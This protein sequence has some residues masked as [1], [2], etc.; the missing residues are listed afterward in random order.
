LLYLA[1]GSTVRRASTNGGPARRAFLRVATGLTLAAPF[2]TA[3]AG[4]LLERTRIETTDLRLRL[5]GLPSELEGLKLLQLSDIHLSP[6][7]SVETL[8]YVIGLSNELKPDIVFLTGD[9]ITTVYDPL[10]ECLRQLSKLRTRYGIFGCHGN[11]EAHAGLEALATT[12]GAQM[13]IQFLRGERRTV[14][15]GSTPL[16]ITGID[17]EPFSK[18]TEYLKGAER[19]LGSG[20]INILM[21][22]NPDVFPVAAAKG[23]DLM[24]AGHTHGGQVTTEILPRTLNPAR[25]LTPYV[26]GLYQSGQRYCYVNRGIGTIG[27]PVRIGCTPEVTMIR[28]TRE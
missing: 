3:A 25:I 10:D 20:G 9:L 5:P 11:H 16:H 18:R 19:L 27:I 6:Y 7:L 23:F 24:L 12:E 15:I 4:A 22:H 26:R 28:L 17:Y 8:A 2:A 14:Q 21:S 13:G 1:V